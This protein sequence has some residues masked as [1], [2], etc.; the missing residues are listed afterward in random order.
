MV[1]QRVLKDARDNPVED[2]SCKQLNVWKG[3]GYSHMFY[4]WD[5]FKSRDVEEKVRERDHSYWV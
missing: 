4:V 2:L 3:K 5:A 1:F